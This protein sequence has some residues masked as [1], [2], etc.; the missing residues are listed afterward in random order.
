MVHPAIAGR[1]ALAAITCTRIADVAVIR[2]ELPTTVMASPL[3]NPVW[4]SLATRH[5]AIALGSDV[6][7]RYPRTYA[8]FLGV[9]RAG[10][11]ADALLTSLLGPGE[12]AWIIGATPRVGPTL[13]LA[14]SET[15]AQLV[16]TTPVPAT[17]GP[18]ITTID[19]ARSADASALTALVYPH[20]FRE[21]TLELGR[22]FGIY[23][24][25][26][27]AALAG[28]RMGDP[29]HV[30]LSAICTHPESVH[31]GYAHRLITYLTN[32][33]LARGQTPFLHVSNGNPHAKG[34]YAAL[35]YRVR[36]ELRFWS[37]RRA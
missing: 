5:R 37:L 8:P 18:E 14:F 9:A 3:D 13:R 20:Y 21:R 4:T 1:S 26:R 27:L 36:A 12:T 23:R 30:E 19:A 2:R 6:L 34:L 31:R 33:A 35:G 17:D 25:G 16:C 7:R 22:Y 24:D 15:L 29:G 28:E 11:A 32:A 10:V